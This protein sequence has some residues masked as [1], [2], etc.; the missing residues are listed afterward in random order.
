M[1]LEQSVEDKAFAKEV[2]KFLDEHLPEERRYAYNSMEHAD[3]DVMLW[4]H[5]K[6]AQ[7]GW[8]VPAWPSEFGGPGWSLN[9]RHIFQ[10]E[11]QKAGAPQ[12]SIFGPLMVGPVVYTFGSDAQK[13]RFL[14]GIENGT[15]LWC[16]G[17]SEPGAGSDL[18]SLKTRADRDGE[19]YVVN[20]Q[21]IWTTQAH[22]ADWIF[23]LVRTRWDV[24][25]Q[26]GISF[27]LI[28]MSSP[29]IEV[30][31]IVSIDGLHHLNEVYLTDVRV[32]ISNLVG[33]ENKGW[34]YAKF[35]LEH[36][37]GGIANTAESRAKLARLR[38]MARSRTSFSEP[39]IEDPG[40]ATRLT[41]LEM[42]LDALEVTEARALS[43]NGGSIDAVKLALPL[44]LLGT[45]LQQDIADLCVE[46]V[47]YG[48][49]PCF[50]EP[51]FTPGSNQS[52][53]FETG[54]KLVQSQF[55]GRASTIYGGTSE[56]QKNIMTKMIL[57]V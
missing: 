11:C 26:E 4:W 7:N 5:E 48:A 56:I 3:K 30:R 1:N 34:T 2:R 57:Q 8:L 12:I 44:K 27:L 45:E 15:E 47:G 10:Q 23:C 37:R 38:E 17:Y 49:A 53:I 19:H 16:Q 36:E 52:S 33:E 35:L 6:L 20:G 40:F 54:P 42:R 51:T 43:A 41:E 25:A 21:K 46:L 18:A 55:F 13:Q 39:P 28:D 22:W 32:P 50:Y 31:P 14:P 9:Q 29:G 24:K